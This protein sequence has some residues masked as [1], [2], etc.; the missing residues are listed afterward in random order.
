M[1]ERPR[2]M[3]FSPAR[4]KAINADVIFV[5]FGYN[6]SFG[7]ERSVINFK[8]ASTVAHEE[9]LTCPKAQKQRQ[10][11]SLHGQALAVDLLAGS[12]KKIA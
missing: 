3:G 12:R 11:R 5:M 9:L 6:Q 7:G 2:N 8:G 1:E 4:S 10:L